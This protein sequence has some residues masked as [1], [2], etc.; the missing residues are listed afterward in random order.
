MAN[1]NNLRTWVLRLTCYCKPLSA[2]NNRKPD[3][4]IDSQ[5]ILCWK[6]PLVITCTNSLPKTGQVSD[7]NCPFC[8]SCPLPLFFLLHKK[9][10]V[11]SISSVQIDVDSHKIQPSVFF[12]EDGTNPALSVPVHTSPTPAPRPSFLPTHGPTLHEIPIS[13]FSQHCKL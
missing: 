6:G 8:K 1:P 4:F 7:W 2:V 9:R 5:T 11:F 13:P 3:K 10:T 12:A